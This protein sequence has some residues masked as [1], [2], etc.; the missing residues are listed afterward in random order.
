MTDIGQINCKIKPEI[1]KGPL[2]DLTEEITVKTLSSNGEIN[3]E[4]YCWKIR[5]NT[6]N[7]NGNCIYSNSGLII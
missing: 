2:G 5:D 7:R 4:V 6:C 1:C 3:R